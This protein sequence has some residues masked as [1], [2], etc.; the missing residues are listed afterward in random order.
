MRRLEARQ[1]PR[2]V[3]ET[4]AALVEQD[5]AGEVGEP[6]AEVDEDRLLPGPDQVDHERHEDQ[7]D[8]PLAHDLVGD[9]HV[10]AARVA[11]LGGFEVH[12]AEE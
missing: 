4:G 2:P 7:I 10:A 9:A 11:D 8:G 1:V 6:L 3:G 5:E 12:G